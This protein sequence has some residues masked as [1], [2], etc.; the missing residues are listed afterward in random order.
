MSRLINH[1]L[2]NIFRW[3][4]NNHLPL[5]ASKSQVMLLSRTRSAFTILPEIK[6]CNDKIS[7]VNKMS[8]LGIIFQS[9]LEWDSHA[10]LQCSRIYNG[11]RHLKLTGGML[12]TP[13][14]LKLFKSLL[15]PHL[16]YG[17][18]FM[19]NASARS[20]DRLRVAI[21]SCV[22]WVFNVSPYARVTHLQQQLLGCSF[23]NF[24]KLRSLITLFRII[25]T[26]KPHYLFEKIQPFRSI[27]ERN[28]VLPRY[29]TSH[30]G[31]TLFVRGIV[32]WNQLPAEIKSTRSLLEFR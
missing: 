30:Y 31:S 12:P 25:N 16:T 19:L 22:R 28:F 21:N 6:I 23:Y 11:L 5:N 2:M 18:E 15:L 29:S 13:I 1:D 20:I 10:N 14:K 32:Y 8:N 3:S 24:L 17:C 9:D 7:Y 27:R 26:F 4:E